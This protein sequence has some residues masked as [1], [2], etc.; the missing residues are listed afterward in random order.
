MKNNHAYGMPQR[1]EE[2]ILNCISKT[3][4]K[5]ILDIGCASGY[6]GKKL[7]ANG[8]EVFGVDISS[9]EINK[10]K[11]VLTE[12]KVVNL[13]NQNLPYESNI[14]DIVIASEIIEH[15]QNPLFVLNECVRVL[16]ND[17]I[18]IITTPN[19]L[20][21]GNRVQFLTG[22]FAYEK[23]GMFDQTHIHFYTWKTLTQDIA[24][25]KLKIVKEDHIF[26]GPSKMNH[27]KKIYTSLFAYQFVVCCRKK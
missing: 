25:T 19:F 18:I 8:A 13:N 14:F 17:G 27:I 5:K 10:A 1:R 6:L 12:A 2:K 24:R 15:L 20:Y 23:I 16:K 11:K 7:L 22:N 26:L 9:D 4:G 21:W 3:Q